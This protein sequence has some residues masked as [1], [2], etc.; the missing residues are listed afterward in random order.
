LTI[1]Q[2]QAAEMSKKRKHVD[3]DDETEQ[4]A[5]VRVVDKDDKK[6]RGKSRQEKSERRS[7]K[8]EKKLKKQQASGRTN[9]IVDNPTE[10]LPPTVTADGTD[11]LAGGEDFVSLNVEDEPPQSTQKKDKSKKKSKEVTVPSIDDEIASP[12]SPHPSPAPPTVTPSTTTK[13]P[14][15]KRKAAANKF[16]LFIGNLP[17]TTT[18]ETLTAHFSSLQPFVLRHST[19]RQTGLSKGFGFLEFE[20]YDRMKTCLKLYH[21]SLFDP[22]VVPET[23]SKTK[24]AGQNSKV[25]GADEAELGPK[26]P[27]KKAGKNARR[28]NVELTA[29]G[30]GT[31]SEARKNRI[32]IKNKKLAE[33]RDRR[34]ARDME[35]KNKL[36]EEKRLKGPATGVNADEGGEKEENSGKGNIHPSRL[37]RMRV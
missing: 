5:K 21:H 13:K 24:K 32:E 15:K 23:E 31:K 10:L 14:K 4:P 9:G 16:I 18:K 26:V 34:F 12:T 8:K 7:K 2:A 29:G 37:K 28:I 30:G 22:D 11:N 1:Q 20:S 36:A 19:D 35:E 17:Y 33:Q 27:K 6:S 3:A 25:E